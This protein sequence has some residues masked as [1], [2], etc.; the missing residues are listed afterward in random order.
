[1]WTEAISGPFLE[2]GITKKLCFSKFYL[3]IKFPLAY[4]KKAALYN[5][6][7]QK[8]R[9]YDYFSEFAS[10]ALH[11]AIFENFV[12][13]TTSCLSQLKVTPSFCFAFK[14]H[15]NVTATKSRYCAI[16]LNRTGHMSFLTGQNRTTKFAGQ[17]LPDRTKSGLIFLNILHTK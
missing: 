17:C 4:F 7:A 12:K 16:G 8:Q 13:S 3:T 6:F 5:F 15:D 9:I 1:L 14:I 10:E 11:I 2:I